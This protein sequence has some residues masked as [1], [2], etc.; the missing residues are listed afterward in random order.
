MDLFASSIH[1]SAVAAPLS[2]PA[3]LGSASVAILG[4][5]TL[6]T[7]F[8]VS[9]N[10]DREQK[11][12]RERLKDVQTEEKGV[13][14]FWLD[15]TRIAVVGKAEAPANSSAV[16][17]AGD[18]G[19][20]VA[21]PI[22]ATDPSTAGDGVAFPA[23]WIATQKRIDAYHEIATAQARKSFLGT[24][25]ATYSGFVIVVGL[26]I[27]AA[28]APTST[29]SITAATVAVIGGGLSTYVGSTFMKSQSQATAQLRRFF[30]QPMENARL[31]SVERL[32]ETLPASERSNAILKVVEKMTLTIDGDGS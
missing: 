27:M 4:I 1:L 13:F 24:Q 29:G 3:F 14:D 15:G 10:A 22:E 16:K 12:L 32:I 21:T 26:G 11:L 20:V 23:L 8:I 31:L 7:R 28:T 9:R 2:D 17:N 5:A 25:V 30:V 6:I 18:A 19:G